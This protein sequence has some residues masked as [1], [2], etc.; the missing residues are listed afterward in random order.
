MDI[1]GLTLNNFQW[2]CSQPGTIPQ[3]PAPSD[4]EGV[5]FQWNMSFPKDSLKLF[6]EAQDDHDRHNIQIRSRGGMTLFVVVGC[7]HTRMQKGVVVWES[8]I[9]PLN[10]GHKYWRYILSLA[11]TGGDYDIYLD[12]AVGFALGR[13]SLCASYV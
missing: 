1:L 10:Y 8:S 11:H 4:Y 6:M 5:D 7:E 13:G 12:M 9:H 3:A 2:V